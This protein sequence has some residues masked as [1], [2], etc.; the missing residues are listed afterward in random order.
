MKAGTKS[1]QICFT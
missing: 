1:V